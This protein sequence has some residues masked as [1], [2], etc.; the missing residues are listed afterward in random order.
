MAEKITQDNCKKYRAQEHCLHFFT[1]NTRLIE[2]YVHK[3]PK[4]NS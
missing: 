2:G 1:G 4:Q 3:I